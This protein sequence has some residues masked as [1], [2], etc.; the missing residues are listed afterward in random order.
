MRVNDFG[1]NVAWIL[2]SNSDGVGRRWRRSKTENGHIVFFGKV[3]TY[4]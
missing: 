1:G 3:H 2:L 4:F